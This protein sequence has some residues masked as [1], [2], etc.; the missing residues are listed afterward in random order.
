[1]TSYTIR[2]GLALLVATALGIGAHRLILLV[3]QPLLHTLVQLH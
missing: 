1:M 3:G 2:L